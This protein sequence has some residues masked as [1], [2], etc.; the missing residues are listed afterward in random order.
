MFSG[1]S[2]DT[3]FAARISIAVPYGV[4]GCMYVFMYVCMYVFVF[5]NVYLCFG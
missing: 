4:C 2:P 3:T 1:S 5:M